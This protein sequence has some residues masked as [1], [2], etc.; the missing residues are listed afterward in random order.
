MCGG[1]YGEFSQAQPVVLASLCCPHLRCEQEGN[2][3]QGERFY[4]PMASSIDARFWK[5]VI[6][7]LK[8][9]YLNTQMALGSIA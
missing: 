5:T 2:E 4:V 8:F 7:S 3:K 6:S 1:F 9:C